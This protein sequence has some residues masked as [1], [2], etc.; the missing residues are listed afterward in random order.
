MLK[1]QVLYCRE[2]SRHHATCKSAACELVQSD[3][4]VTQ[5]FVSLVAV[6]VA[7]VYSCVTSSNSV[8]VLPQSYRGGT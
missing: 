8:A 6:A 3:S 1:A 7:L 4:G 2:R 5:F